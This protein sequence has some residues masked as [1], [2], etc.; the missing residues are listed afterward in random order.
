MKKKD[1][2][3]VEEGY[4]KSMKMMTRASKKRKIQKTKT[5]KKMRTKKK[6]MMMKKSK[7]EEVEVESDLVEM[8]V[9]DD[10]EKISE[11]ELSE[12]NQEKARTI[13]KAV[14]SKVS[15]IKEQLES[16]FEENLK[17]SVEQVKGDLVGSS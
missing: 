13:F 9:E 16:D 10:L 15:E 14:S 12:E 5:R 4:L 8:E 17:T 3:E 7:K 11:L 2:D 1:D 6:E